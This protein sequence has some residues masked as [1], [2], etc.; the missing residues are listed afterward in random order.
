MEV[1]V[2]LQPNDFKNYFTREFNYLNIWNEET[3]YKLY[4]VVYY[5]DYFYQSLTNKN[6][7]NNPETSTDYWQIDNEE[8][9]NNYVNDNDI[10]KAFFQALN[11]INYNLFGKSQQEQELLKMC[12]LYL[13]A[14]YLLVDL[15]ISKGNG[16]Y[17]G[18]ITS[19]SVDGVSASYSYPQKILNSPYF[20]SFINDGFGQKYLD[21]ILPRLNGYIATVKGTTS[22]K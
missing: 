9:Y 16:A 3:S 17:N 6:I 20:S 8:D 22:F 5:N 18:I 15:K 19:K 10:T 11:N 21:F 14:H 1:L 13:T 2:N 4:T 12:Y 7:A